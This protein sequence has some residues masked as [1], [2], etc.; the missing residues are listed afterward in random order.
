MSGMD[1]LKNFIVLLPAFLFGAFGIKTI[2]YSCMGIWF[3]PL[4]LL[5]NE[6]TSFWP[7]IV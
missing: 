4:G 1:K 6:Q 3:E 5:P 7:Q 2:Y